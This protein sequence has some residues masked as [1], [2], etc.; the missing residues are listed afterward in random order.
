MQQKILTPTQEMLLNLERHWLTNLQIA[1]AR[2]HASAQ[3]RAVLEQS[4]RQLDELFL[5]VIV[6][7]FNAG[8]SAF[9]NALFGERLLEEGVTPTTSRIQ[10][11]KFGREYERV[12]IESF[13]HKTAEGQ[14][15][16]GQVDV[17]TAPAPLLNEINIVDTPGT[18]AIYRE[19]EA[20]TRDF[21][22]RSDLILFVTSVDRPF[23]ESERAFLQ[24][25]REWGKKVIVVLNKIDI[26]SDEAEINDVQSFIA[27]NARALL[28]FKP[29][30]FPISARQALQGRIAGDDALL[31]ASGILA[32]E[33]HI[34]TTLDE[35]ERIRLKLLNPIGV[36]VHLID[37]YVALIDG[38]LALL[39]ED[40]TVM[41]DV[42]RQLHM[43]REDMI[44]EFGYRLSDVEK[45]LVEFENRGL[46]YFDE[47]MRLLRVVD[48]LNR[49]KLEAEFQAIVIDESPQLIEDRIHGMV[50]WLIDSNYQQWQ[51]VMEHVISRREKHADRII[52]R[53]GGTFDN[54]RR[55]LI[56][57]VSRVAQQA[58]Q[59]YDHE[60]ESRRIASSLQIAVAGTALAE[61]GAL[62][63]GAAIA[64]IATTSLMDFTGILAAGTLA[65]LGLLVIPARKRQVKQDLREKVAAVR[66]DLINTLTEQFEL[67]LDRGLHEIEVAISPYTRF[68][69]AE[70]KHLDSTRHELLTIREWLDR[71]SADVQTML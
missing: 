4:V 27:E 71:Q 58:L 26:L 10:L 57:T 36:A 15:I 30:I 64:T 61:V 13:S 56:D 69:R 52:G 44:R 46:N 59:S 20:L 33:A 8:K 3:D 11:L 62:G 12:A 31:E 9:I 39:R 48:L 49:A 63:L 53:V 1:L 38:R 67:E 17:Y 35:E 14:E 40:F 50:D 6:G 29:D 55:R 70:R 28:G 18:N 66:E 22:P 41:A 19:H 43:Y 54:D 21:V 5:L 25:L 47:T 34:A 65:V 42:E 7:E 60:L 32:L 16:S 45:V 2:F 51:A 23:T 68:I 24:K 37:K